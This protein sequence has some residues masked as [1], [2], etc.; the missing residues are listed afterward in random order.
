MRIERIKGTNLTDLGQ[1]DWILPQGLAAFFLEYSN[2]QTII[3]FLLQFFYADRENSLSIFDSHKGLLE[4][5]LAGD[6]SRWRIWQSGREKNARAEGSTWLLEDEQGKSVALPKATRLGEYL[7]TLTSEAFLQ[8][9][10]VALPE[11]KFFKRIR[12]IRQGGDEKFSLARARASLT[13]AQKKMNEQAE[14]MVKVK[15]EY[16]ALRRD[17]ETAYRQQDEKR[18]LVI[19]LKNLQ[20]R[21]KIVNDQLAAEAKLQE[22]LAVFTQ[23]PDYREL[24]QL[25]GEVTRLEELRRQAELNLL[26]LTQ[27]S[28][29]DW[30]MIESLREEC[31]EWAKV[32]E[33]AQNIR[34]RVKKRTNNLSQL[35]IELE[36]SG[37][38]DMGE[39]PEQRLYRAEEDRLSA[40]REL[41]ELAELIAEVK[42]I[43]EKLVYE[44]AQLKK[45]DLFSSLT[46]TE[47]IK[48]AKKEKHLQ[49]WKNSR[50][51]GFFDR[52]GQSIGVGNIEDKLALRLNLEYQAYQ[53]ENYA[54]FKTKLQRSRKQQQRVADLQKELAKLQEI[55]GREERLQR[56]LITRT[57]LL[58]RVFTATKTTNLAGWQNGWQKFCQKKK[59]QNLELE[60]LQLDLDELKLKENSLAVCVEQ[61]RE[62]TGNWGAF[63]AQRDQVLTEVFK[64]ARQLRIK[65]EAERELAEYSQ[66]LEKALGKRQLEQLIKILEPLAEL[67]RESNLSDE[68]RQV[69]HTNINNEKLEIHRQRIALNK[70]LQSIQKFSSLS[71]LEKKIAQVK[72][73]WLTYENLNKALQE[74]QTLLEASWREWQVKY[75]EELEREAEWV[76]SKISSCSLQATYFAY[77]MAVAQLALGNNTD[78]PLFF[79]V[80]QVPE[81]QNLWQDI[82]EYLNLLSDSRQVVL[83]TPNLNLWQRVSAVNR[84]RSVNVKE[85]GAQER[86]Y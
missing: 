45:F 84:H 3:K 25:Q 32:E 15:N 53:V 86:A 83:L 63:A 33:Q 58:N 12:N 34:E 5:W 7:F 14:T 22:R 41:Q 29:V 39:D 4:T 81:D 62:K 36:S 2:S 60:R 19:K 47:V 72:D 56:I 23:N 67:E 9:G 38:Q 6:H 21:E 28:Q 31:M 59:Q 79:I 17:W 16:D 40:H 43:K 26:K 13:G 65:E 66:R 24:R 30:D 80:E 46:G 85:G 74:A 37:Y 27:D 18:L 44:Q 11:D 64:V 70:R 61:L 52:V 68:E 1:I 78:M 55:T 77:R 20:E 49:H 42:E 8:A 50:I 71:Q 35:K 76:L 10:I 57:E 73:Q 51:A 54:E 75:S 69:R 82:L 48:F